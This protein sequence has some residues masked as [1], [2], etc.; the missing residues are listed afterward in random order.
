MQVKKEQN[1]AR[2]FREESKI[3]ATFMLDEMSFRRT[4][5]RIMEELCIVSRYF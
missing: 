4:L 3:F 2:T 5:E 1:F